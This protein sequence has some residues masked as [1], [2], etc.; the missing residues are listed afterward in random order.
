MNTAS[1]W[2]KVCLM[3]DTDTK[4][5]DAS[6]ESFTKTVGTA[7]TSVGNGVKNS[8]SGTMS[9]IRNFFF[10]VWGMILLTV[11]TIG[12]L[13][14]L[15]AFAVSIL[16]G[17]TSFKRLCGDQ[18]IMACLSLA[19]DVPQPSEPVVLPNQSSPT[20]R[21]KQ[22]EQVSDKDLLPKNNEEQST[23]TTVE[24]TKPEETVLEKSEIQDT[25]AETEKKTEK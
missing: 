16:D 12:G 2:F 11:L 4:K 17:T 7:F 13:I 19:K 9:W 15:L 14:V 8:V 24:N 20:Q 18:S 23:E 5:T 21:S 6:N 22:T 25:G 10:K 3:N 1:D